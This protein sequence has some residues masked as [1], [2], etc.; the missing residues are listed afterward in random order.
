MKLSWLQH[1]RLSSPDPTFLLLHISHSLS[2]WVILLSFEALSSFAGHTLA[3]LSSSQLTFWVC[4]PASPCNT[5]TPS[6]TCPLF[7]PTFTMAHSTIHHV[8]YGAILRINLHRDGH[9]LCFISLKPLKMSTPQIC[10]SFSLLTR[11]T[12]PWSR[13]PCFFPHSGPFSPSW[14]R[15][16]WESQLELPGTVPFF[17]SNYF[18]SKKG[19]AAVVYQGWR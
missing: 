19:A 5:H 17:S 14:W 12:L 6:P 13:C 2:L 8:S 3:G 11:E 1:V 10:P 16:S 4:H 9:E 18:A 7:Q 15:L